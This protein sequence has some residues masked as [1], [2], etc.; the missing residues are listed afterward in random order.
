LV[1]GVSRFLKERMFDCSD[2]F[3]VSLCR[4]CRAFS[5][6]ENCCYRCNTDNVVQVNMPYSSKLLFQELIS[7]GI[8]PEMIV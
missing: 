4:K 5:D 2:P 6:Y 8:K 1:H 3:T 7:V